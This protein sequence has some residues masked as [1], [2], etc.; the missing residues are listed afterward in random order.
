[1]KKKTA[2]RTKLKSE[3]NSPAMEVRILRAFQVSDHY[4]PEDYPS[5]TFEHG[6]WWIVLGW[7]GKVFSVVDA[8]GG[9]SIDGFDFE[10][11]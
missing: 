10:E 5:T 9:S 4:E 8:T 1:M 7:S 11:T 2:S 6:Q 3:T